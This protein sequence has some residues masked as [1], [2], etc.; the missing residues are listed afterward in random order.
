MVGLND[1]QST[2]EY[3]KIP[4]M[5]YP[6]NENHVQIIFK[7]ANIRNEF[8]RRFEQRMKSKEEDSNN[9]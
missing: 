9:T 3:S 4:G 2:A 8:W 6:K 1:L 7:L 5:Y